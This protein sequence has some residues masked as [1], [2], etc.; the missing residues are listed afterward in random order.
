MKQR[1]QGVV[2]VLALIIL[3]VL[4]LIGLSAMSTSTLEQKMSGNER[5]QLLALHSAE[6]AA[7]SAETGI[8]AIN[9]ATL[10]KNFA[11]NK[12]GYYSATNPAPANVFDTANWTDKNSITAPAP[13]GLE[14]TP[15]QYIVEE[16][17]R[18]TPLMAQEYGEHP[19]ITQVVRITAR[20]T[21]G[22]GTANALVE[23]YYRKQ[24]QPG[25]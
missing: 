25:T 6:Q 11:D 5:Q 19:I 16:V 8:A 15:P 24:W 23:T 22:D 13:K 10:N 14:S 4:T 17:Q 18:D 9:W 2:L 7:R 21:G 1:Q 3:L 20:G 12:P